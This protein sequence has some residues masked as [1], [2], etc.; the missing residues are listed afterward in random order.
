MLEILRHVREARKPEGDRFSTEWVRPFASRLA[1]SAGTT[2]FWRGDAADA[3]Y[4]TEGGKFRL[5][6]IDKTVLEGDITGE[7]GFLT[8][9]KKRTLTSECVEDGELLV[10][11]YH[12]LAELY[13]QNPKLSLYIMRL[14][15]RRLLDDVRRL[16]AAAAG[17]G[18]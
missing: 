1:V 12:R 6:E 15:G 2:I 14:A 13:M 4:I 3:M 8:P 16:E 18:A 17:R 5:K 10:L 7:L 9:D 11:P